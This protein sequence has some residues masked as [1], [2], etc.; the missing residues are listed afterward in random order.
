MDNPKFKLLIVDHERAECAAVHAALQQYG[1]AVDAANDAPTAMQLLRAN[2]YQLVLCASRLPQA[3]PAEL[4][5]EARRSRPDAQLIL[6]T[7]CSSV[8]ACDPAASG[9]FGCVCRPIDPYRLHLAVAKAL[10]F[11]TVVTEVHELRCHGPVTTAAEAAQAAVC[12]IRAG[13][14]ISQCEEL[15]IRHTLVHAT[16][17]RARAA[18]LLGISRR[19][20]QYKLKEYGLVGRKHEPALPVGATP[21]A[22]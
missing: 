4:L 16:T 7:A 8:E 19:T 3:T 12:E 18:R 11:E 6:I 9:A 15:L 14:T 1:Y 20:L 2:A 5:A 13:M 17:N 10:E 21:V 22:S